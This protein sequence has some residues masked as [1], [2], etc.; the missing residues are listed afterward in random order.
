MWIWGRT[1]KP[2]AKAQYLPLDATQWHGLESSV[3]YAGWVTS[4][5]RE[6]DLS[7]AV[8]EGQLPS[9]LRG[10]YYRVGPG[11]FERG[12]LRRNLLIDADGMVRRFQFSA[13][14]VRFQNKHIR[15]RKFV[16]EEKAQT[17]LFP[18]IAMLSPDAANNSALNL[19]NQA[20]V[21]VIENGGRVFVFDE[22]QMPYEVNPE[23]LETI[24]PHSF[25]PG[26][27]NLPFYAHHKRDPH[28][29]DLLLLSRKEGL[30]PKISVVTIDRNNRFISESAP[31]KLPSGFGTYFHDWSITDHYFVFLIHPKTLELDGLSRAMAGKAPIGSALQF[32]E[33][34]KTALLFVS[35]KNTD[36]QFV[37]EA[38][39]VHCWHTVN[40]FEEGD[41]VV[42]DYTGC[43]TDDALL[44]PESPLSTIMRGEL[45]PAFRVNEGVAY[46][47]F[48]VDCKAKKLLEDRVIN[49]SGFY[50]FPTIAPSRMG[51]PYRYAY[52]FRSDNQ[53]LLVS[54]IAKMDVITGRE[55]CFDF[56]EGNYVGEPMFVPRRRGNGQEDFG[57]L[58]T[59]VYESLT[60]TS[61]LAVLRADAITQGP[62]CK[63]RL[64]FHL[65]FGFH[66]SWIG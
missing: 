62:V 17:Y 23:T 18:T 22:F 36:H 66:G 39:A 8:I 34:M 52:S 30:Q 10:S 24:G 12:N 54:T 28:N 42:I 2:K 45:D 5:T 14:G 9:D 11:L 50:E 38:N 60:K 49:D 51:R 64:P 13:N 43:T 27:P 37:I 44:N 3:P 33:K 25:V 47:R 56:G 20:S 16:E 59:E 58:L 7:Q 65:P 1:A 29:G 6:Y 41:D 26:K 35:R 48:R 32:S 31:I 21:N 15:T 40:A 55:E 46:R 4:Q 57:Y 63:V 19:Q 61:Y 53:P